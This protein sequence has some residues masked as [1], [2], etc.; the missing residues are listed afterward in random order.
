MVTT[1]A[2]NLIGSITDRMPAI[3]P[4]ETWPVW[5]GEADADAKAVLQTATVAAGQCC[6]RR[7]V[8]RQQSKPPG[9]IVL[10]ARR[11]NKSLSS[12]KG[13][14]KTTDHRRHLLFNLS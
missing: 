12:L 6:H 11:G 13:N 1:P 8:E 10:T 7:A 3:L 9:R 5:L 4:R 14:E 2:N